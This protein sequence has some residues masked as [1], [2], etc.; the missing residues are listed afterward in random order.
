MFKTVCEEAAQSLTGNKDANAG[1]QLLNENFRVVLRIKNYDG[2]TLLDQIATFFSHQYDSYRGIAELNS[3]GETLEKQSDHFRQA[4]RSSV[5]ATNHYEE[6]ARLKLDALRAFNS[7]PEQAKGHICRKIYE[8]DGGGHREGNYGYNRAV[9]NIERI[10]SHNNESPIKHA[11]AQ[12]TAQTPKSPNFIV[13]YVHVESIKPTD[14]SSTAQEIRKLY[15]LE[16]LKQFLADRYKSND[17]VTRKYRSMHPD[18]KELINKSIWLASY[19]PKELGFGD[20][21]VSR[22]PSALLG[23][24]N[25]QGTNIISQLI[26]HQQEKIL[27]LRL[28]DEVVAF[29]NSSGNKNPHQVL[30]LFNRLSDKAKED[31]RGRVWKRDGGEHNPD[32]GGWKY[33]FRYGWGLYG[34]IERSKPIR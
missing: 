10:L 7:L 8:L 33:F 14:S 26:S 16:D 23:I 21:F 30:D 25:Q 11:I 32:I 28:Y 3:I 5:V 34:T 27:A 4:G 31:F 9:D 2:E 18:V 13:T 15:D 24:K 29:N 17:F 20:N 19:Q 1:E 12:C 6:A 22:N